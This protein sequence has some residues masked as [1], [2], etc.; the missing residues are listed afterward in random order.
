MSA[1]F[2]L[3]W[4]CSEGK[5]D[6]GPHTFTVH[7]G[8]H[9]TTASCGGWGITVGA[10]VTIGKATTVWRVTYVWTE[11]IEVVRVNEAGKFLHR[12]IDRDRV[13]VVGRHQLRQPEETT[14]NCGECGC[15]REL[16]DNTY[17]G[18]RFAR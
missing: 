11:L 15:Y 7:N 5:V 10:H 17:T 12:T 13:Q 16:A 1:G 8:N 6:H 18:P 2:G 3:H 9:F 4:A 14:P